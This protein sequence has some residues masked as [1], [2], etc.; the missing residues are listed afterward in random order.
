MK[1]TNQA[2]TCSLPSQGLEVSL[3]TLLNKSSLINCGDHLL[4][5]YTT[6]LHLSLFFQ[7]LFCMYGVCLYMAYVYGYPQGPEE[8]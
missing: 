4:F 3:V 1:P 2:S 7:I 5:K 8:V 6:I